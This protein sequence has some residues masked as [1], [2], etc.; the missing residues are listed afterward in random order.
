MMKCSSCNQGTLKPAYLDSLFA[1]HQ[2][3]HCGG[4]W[5]YLGDYLRWQQSNPQYTFD[6]NWLL[7]Y[8]IQETKKSML[9]PV[10]GAIMVKYR[11]SSQTGHRLDL[12]SRVN[13]I[14]LDKGEWEL[15]KQEGLA[16][17]LNRIFTDPWQRKI[18]NQTAAETLKSMYI[19]QFGDEVYQ[20]V[21]QMRSWLAQQPNKNE[22]IAYLIANDPYSA[23]R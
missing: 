4:N 12:S 23:I 14:W 5:L 18:R 8:E 22:L 10:T 2:C 9:C 13:A 16:G 1:C 11:I 17:Q 20:Q 7:D 6:E 21:S 3:D 19:E 15:L